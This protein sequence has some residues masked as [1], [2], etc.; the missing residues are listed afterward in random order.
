MA[1]K[2]TT[3]TKPP[4]MPA[5]LASKAVEKTKIFKLQLRRRHTSGIEERP[6]RSKERKGESQSLRINFHY[7]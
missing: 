6:S 3:C 7:H 4:Y 5:L 2:E 1:S